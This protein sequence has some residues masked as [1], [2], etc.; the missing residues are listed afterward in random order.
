LHEV[1]SFEL[2]V[3]LFYVGIIAIA[4][5]AASEHPNGE[6]L[7]KFMIVFTLSW[8]SFYHGIPGI[9]A[10]TTMQKFWS[11]VSL[12]VSWFDA[13]DILR[14]LMI[15]FTLTCLLGFTV[16][17]NG[18]WE[19]TWTA[20]ISFYVATRWG[21]SLYFLWMASLIPMVRA[22]MIATAFVS[23]LPGVLYIASI[24]VD[25]PARQAVIWPAIVLDIFGPVL[26]TVIERGPTWLG[27]RCCAWFR[28]IFD[29]TP[30]QNIEHKIERTN[31]FV[32]LVFGYSVIALL[33][34]SSV[35]FPLNAFF[36]KGVL[37]LIIA[38]TYN[39]VY[40]EIDTWNLHT[41][42]IRRH[43][44]S[45]EYLIEKDLALT[46]ASTAV[47]WQAA[48]LPFIMGYVLAGAALSKI[49]LA[50]DVHDADP[51][52]LAEPYAGRSEEKV[53]QGLRWFFC[54]G[55]AVAMLM[56]T[57]IAM[58]HT[59]RTI[60]N[61]R[62]RKEYRIGYRIAI[63]IAMLLLPLAGDSLD[64]LEL[65]GTCCGLVVSILILEICG[66]A[67]SRTAFWGLSDF[68]QRHCAY[69]AKCHVSKREFEEHI[70]TGKVVNVEEMARKQ[71][72]EENA[73]E[74]MIV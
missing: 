60:P 57:F 4:G 30:G 21:G 49:V 17:I 70:R 40:F 38:F 26:L 73:A 42:A 45:G 20:L 33:Y 32:A 23:F 8:V 44:Y 51:E 10:L 48:H 11:D 2:F 35:E 74:G 37:F 22:A 15:L 18:A 54:G 31:A 36:G 25:Q 62:L 6:A 63:S 64:S 43:F 50:H 59:Y 7:V 41:H 68:C 29:F 58:S 55:L 69:S 46:N 12:Y 13:D 72:T 56:M 14:R 5:D 52:W 47:G 66:S 3:D 1:A 24:H 19:T 28:K 34:Q 67:S 9:E 65:V 39:W 16:N 53:H 27:P 71:K 61:V